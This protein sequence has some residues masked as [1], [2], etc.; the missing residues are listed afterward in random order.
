MNPRV[1]GV[2]DTWAMVVARCTKT[3]PSY[4]S[5]QDSSPLLAGNYLRLEVRVTTEQRLGEP[6]YVPFQAARMGWVQFADKS[7]LHGSACSGK[8]VSECAAHRFSSSSRAVH[9]P[10]R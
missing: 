7:N 3:R 9:K 4:S 1:I 8:H 5:F 10:E 2:E 6:L